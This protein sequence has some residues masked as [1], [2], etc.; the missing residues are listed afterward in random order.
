MDENFV[1][2]SFYKFGYIIKSVKIIREKSNINKG[3]LG[4]GFVEFETPE[5]AKEVLSYL[6]GKLIPETKKT[7][8]L[9]SASYSASKVAAMGNFPSK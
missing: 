5:I 3:S 6:N 7:F 2:K 1:C 4:Y 8:K 9:N